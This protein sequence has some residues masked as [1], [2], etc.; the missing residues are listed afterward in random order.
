MG[1]ACGTR[2]F[3][4]AEQADE[5]EVLGLLA[6]QVGQAGVRD[7][8]LPRMPGRDPA[9]DALAALGQAGFRVA[10]R[11]RSSDCLALVEGG[12]DEHRRRFAGYEKSVRRFANRM[13]PLWDVTLDERG[14]G[15]WPGSRRAT[16]C[17]PASTPTAGRSR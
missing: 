10:R 4:G 8:T 1:A 5:E 13:K 17:S 2:P 6:E 15:R 12:W 3:L 14:L 9:T 7:L 16:G 11:E